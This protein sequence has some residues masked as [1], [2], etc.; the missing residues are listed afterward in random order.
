MSFKPQN[1]QRT[2]C[3]MFGIKFRITGKV[4]PKKRA[5]YNRDFKR[6]TSRSKNF[7]LFQTY[8]FLWKRENFFATIFTKLSKNFFNSAFWAKLFSRSCFIQFLM[9]FPLGF[10]PK[11]LKLLFVFGHI[12]KKADNHAQFEP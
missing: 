2:F 1:F 10:H 8:K 11:L 12:C 5:F 7:S 9:S 6:N 4:L 3:A